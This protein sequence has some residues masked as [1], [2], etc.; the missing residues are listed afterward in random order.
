M[1]NQGTN[2]AC[3][4]STDP[5]V[6]VDTSR[7]ST[8]ASFILNS[9]AAD[10]VSGKWVGVGKISANIAFIGGTSSTNIGSAFNA[11]GLS[12]A[13]YGIPSSVCWSA[14]DGYFYMITD[15]GSILRSQQY[16][17]GWT[18]QGNAGVSNAT[19]SI[20]AIGTT[21]YVVASTLA[22]YVW[23]STT[24]N[25]GTS[26]AN[27]N[28]AS[29]P[30]GSSYR[31]MGSVGAGGYYS[32]T[33]LSTNGT[34]LV[35]NNTQGLAY[36]LTPSVS[37]YGMRLPYQRAIGTIQTVNS[38]QFMYGGYDNSIY[39]NA[40]GYFTST[41][42]GT[43][44]GTYVSMGN[45]VGAI[46]PPPNRFNYI[47]GV[48]YLTN[49]SSD[50]QIYNG[51]TVTNI[52]NNGFGLGSTFAGINV[53]NPSNGWAIDGTNLVGTQSNGKLNA[54]CKT[55]TPNNFLYAATVTAS[56]VEIS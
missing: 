32:G 14:V 40:F 36:V 18:Y 24:L 54:V 1:L 48:Y 15:N 11:T 47:G 55:T 25:G 53:V 38:N 20:K 21:L 30:N 39:G 45:T 27:N 31:T 4:L 19:C 16:G 2:D 10:P 22:N 34:D 46:S 26:W 3:M 6:S 9:A 43:T 52:P 41:N 50:S 7:G 51:T 13:T 56:I 35:W 5:T 42:L 23:T 44:Y 29:T 49:T 12:L 8:L 28:Y 17:S 37:R 33:S